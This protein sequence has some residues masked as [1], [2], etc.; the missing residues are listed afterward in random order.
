MTATSP[1]PLIKPVWRGWIH[2]LMTPTALALGVLL[3]IAA[4]GARART[5]S[6]IFAIASLVLFGVSALYH[7]VSWGP[8]GMA[9]LRRLDHANIYLLIAG[10]YTPMALL[11]LPRQKAILLL[12]VIWTGALIGVAFRMLWITAPRLLY[13]WLYVLLGWAAVVFAV[14]FFRA[15]WLPMTLILLGGLAYTAGA[16]IYGTKRPDP[17]PARFG[18]HEVF[19]AL[20]VVAFV[21]HWNAVYIVASEPPALW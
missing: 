12:T 3:V 21:L 14:D 10:T 8:R 19:H 9:I 16:I 15:Q 4:D 11:C 20:T 6:A 17:S 18:F 2:A 13:V 1:L 5:G 7:R